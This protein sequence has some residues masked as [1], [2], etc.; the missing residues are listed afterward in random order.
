MARGP[1]FNENL[2]IQSLNNVDIYHIACRILKLQPNPYA[3][4]GSLANLTTIFRTNE[5]TIVPNNSG[6]SHSI[7]LFSL[8]FMFFLNFN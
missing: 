7:S 4:A 5:S 3:T 6:Y 2:T 1:L 8:L